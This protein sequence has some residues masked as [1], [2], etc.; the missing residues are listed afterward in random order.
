MKKHT[1]QNENINHN[2]S[3]DNNHCAILTEGKVRLIRLLYNERLFTQRELAVRF[4]VG[5]STISDIVRY[6]TWNHMPDYSEKCD[7]I[8]AS[9]VRVRGEVVI[10]VYAVIR[11][12]GFEIID[13]LTVGEK[14]IWQILVDFQNKYP[15]VY[16]DFI[17]SLELL[18]L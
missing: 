12:H 15:R 11:G 17:N 4:A 18:I 14:T 16:F 13:E 7:Y 6:R 8:I 2:C 10:L 9:M 3:G 1:L 5:R